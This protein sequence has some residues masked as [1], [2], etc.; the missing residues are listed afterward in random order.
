MRLMV[1]WLNPVLAASMRLD[2]CV[3]PLGVYS[4][5]SRTMCLTVEQT[6]YICSLFMTHESKYPPAKPG[7]LLCE[8]LKAA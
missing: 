4:R 3:A 1:D 2:Q 7:A 6:S 5:V 8:P